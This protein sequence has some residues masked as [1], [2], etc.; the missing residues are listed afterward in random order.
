MCEYD[1]ELVLGVT[2]DHI[3]LIYRDETWGSCR[4]W[5]TIDSIT[6][7]SD[8]TAF[9]K[10]VND[11]EYAKKLP[12]IPAWEFKIGKRNINDSSKN[13]H[14]DCIYMC[15]IDNK[16]IYVVRRWSKIHP[17]CNRARWISGWIFFLIINGEV[18]AT[19]DKR[20][21]GY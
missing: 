17:S 14:R 8:P 18:K 2:E 20:K 7:I 4:H 5:Q 6:E 15:P 16:K 11:K 19:V 21:I 10:I 9:S 1:G 3:L 13:R 12:F